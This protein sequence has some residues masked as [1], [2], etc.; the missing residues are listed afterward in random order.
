MS[1]FRHLTKLYRRIG[2][3]WSL[4]IVSLLAIAV[5]VT[6]LASPWDR[7]GHQS[8]TL[9]L[10]CANG[11]NRPVNEIIHDYLDQYG[12]NVQAI[13]DG[14]GNLLSRIRAKNGDGDLFISADSGFMRDAQKLGLV[15]EIIPVAII[16]PA[17]VVH[18]PTQEK[19]TAAGS[20]VAGVKD[21]LRD[22]LKVFLGNPEGTAI[23]NVGRRF[24]QL[25]GIWGELERRRTGRGARVS[26][27][28]T[29]NEVV[30]QVQTNPDSVGLAWDA[31]GKQFPGVVVVPLPDAK[32][33][34]ERIEIGVLRKSANP[35]TALRFARY[36]TAGDA[37]LQVFAKYHFEPMPDADAWRVSPRLHLSAGAMLEPGVRDV[38][39]AFSEREGVRIDTSYA[40]CGILVSQMESIRRGDKPGYFPD[41]YL[42]CDVSFADMVKQWFEPARII[43]EN[44][45]VIIVPKG[46]P[47]GIKSLDD[48]KR[49]DVRIGLPHP[50]NSAIGKLV[51]DMLVH[52]EFPESA[53]NTKKNPRLINSDAAHTLVNQMC[54]GHLDVAIVGRSNAL[55]NPANIEKHIDVID[56]DRPGAVAVQT[57]SIARDSGNRQLMRRFLD[58][59]LAPE[60][61][62]RFERLGF[63]VKIK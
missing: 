38:V 22:D 36:L 51:R 42:S 31:V 44:R 49:D 8:G 21:L 45:L 3:G 55:S 17:L 2:E 16:R 46:N 9:L 25:A 34:F 6:L 14:S 54:A 20:P 11:M 57:F 41:A 19:L 5:L 60:S 53:Y 4:G 30:Q 24:F 1:R 43:L 15:A 48:L 10:Y 29:V 26:T 18:G 23:G 50:R 27:V 33:F 28:G 62:M 61:L 13:Y 39:K 58:A 12:V 59:L 32:A 37:G 56:I 35:A 63:T 52:A 7:P 47:K 40:G